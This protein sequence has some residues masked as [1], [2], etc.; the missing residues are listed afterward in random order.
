MCV[1]SSMQ[2]LG[3]TVMQ[4]PWVKA[5][6]ICIVSDVACISSF[7]NAH[8]EDSNNI[9]FLRYL[10]SQVCIILWRAFTQ[11]FW[12]EACCDLDGKH[13]GADS[14]DPDTNIALICSLLIDFCIIEISPGCGVW[15]VAQ[16]SLI[17]ISKGRVCYAIPLQ[18][19]KAYIV[20]TPGRGV[21]LVCDILKTQLHALSSGSICRHRKAVLTSMTTATKTGATP[22]IQ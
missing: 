11:T 2:N 18:K 6:V 10:H 12:E 13:P 5:L 20:E 3:K 8:I 22:T 21:S 16:H 9:L 1:L 7:V 15:V 4:L 19:G 14:T 17:A